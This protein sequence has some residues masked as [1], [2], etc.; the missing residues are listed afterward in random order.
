M[1]LPLLLSFPAL[2]EDEPGD[3]VCHWFS[4]LQSTI[5]C[6]KYVNLQTTMQPRI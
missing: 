3:A 6:D 4:I 2:C 5:I 1:L